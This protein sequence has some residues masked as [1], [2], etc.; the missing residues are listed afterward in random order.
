MISYETRKVVSRENRK[1]ALI[2]RFSEQQ[3]KS[4]HKNNFKGENEMIAL[5]V[6]MYCKKFITNIANNLLQM[7]H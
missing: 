4:A 7:S 2:S 3:I 5:A 6:E 1:L